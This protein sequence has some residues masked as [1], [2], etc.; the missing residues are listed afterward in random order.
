[1]GLMKPDR[2]G[3]LFFKLLANKQDLTEKVRQR[4]FSLQYTDGAGI[5]SDM[6]E[7]VLVDDDPLKPIEVPPAGAELQLDLGYQLAHRD[8][9]LFIV[10]EIE[11]AGYPCALVIRGR[12]APFTESKMGKNAMQTQKNRS[13]E[14]GYSLQKMLETIA[15]EHG[16]EPKISPSMA[17]IQLPHIDQKEESDLNFLLRICRKYDAVLKPGGGKLIITKRGEALSASGEKLPTV[18]IN[19]EDVVSFRMSQKKRDSAGTVISYYKPSKKAARHEVKVGNGEPVKRIGTLYP[20]KDMAV[21]AAKAEWNSRQRD[22]TEL[23]ITLMGW[24]DLMAEMIAEVKGVHAAADGSWLVKTCAHRVGDGGYTVDLT[25]ELPNAEKPPEVTER[26]LKSPK[27]GKKDDGLDDD[28]P[29][30]VITLPPA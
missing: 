26:E 10:D 12:A 8:M 18:T 23:N 17:G 29:A 9:G 20:S 11:V 25:M 28:G 19:R 24:P 3:G 13:W 22:E 21:E 7:I 2:V 4:L 5:E 16:L 30:G 6:L 1:M 14:K 27:V 15:K